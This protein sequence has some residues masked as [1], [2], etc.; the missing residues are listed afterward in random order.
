MLSK[1]EFIATNKAVAIAAAI[2]IQQQSETPGTEYKHHI[3][4]VT[5]LDQAAASN[6]NKPYIHYKT[7]YKLY[8][9]YCKQSC[10]ET[11]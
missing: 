5:Y 6:L 1:V 9:T 3:Q 7:T 10:E 4:T 8:Q 11:C 2:L